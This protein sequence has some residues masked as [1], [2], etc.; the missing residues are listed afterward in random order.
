[1]RGA[2]GAAPP[3]GRIGAGATVGDSTGC[4]SAGR[5][6]LL[7]TTTASAS[8]FMPAPYRS[9]GPDWPRSR[10]VHAR[11]SQQRGPIA[12]G[13][14]EAVIQPAGELDSQAVVAFTRIN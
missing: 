10:D 7:H 13:V 12:P 6:Y 4:A 8:T 11:G 9:R 1:M 5:T 2:D 14:T 3:A